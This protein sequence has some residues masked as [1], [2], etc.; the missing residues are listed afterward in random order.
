MGDIYFSRFWRLGGPRSRVAALA[1]GETTL[2]GLPT[3]TFLY[4]HR[5]EG[6]HNLWSLPLFFY[7]GANAITGAPSTPNYL[8]K[9][10]PP[11]NTLRITF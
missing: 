10:L 9:M 11:D 8:P 6:E 1:L 5:A 7:K 2:P 4:P 3:G